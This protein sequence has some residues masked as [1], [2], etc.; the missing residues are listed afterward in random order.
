MRNSENPAAVAKGFAATVLIELSH[1][2]RAGP[3]V[4]LTLKHIPTSA[5]VAPLCFSS[6]TSV[7]MAIASWTFPS[8]SPPTTRERRKVRKSVAQTQRRTLR[9]LPAM[10]KRRAVRRPYLSETVPI[11]GEAMAWR[12]LEYMLAIYLTRIFPLLTRKDYLELHQ[13]GQCHVSNR[14]GVQKKLCTR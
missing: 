2:P 5:M 9:M 3:N 8:D 7:A 12:R 10:L 11:T 6:D 1:A 4:K 14:S 13:V